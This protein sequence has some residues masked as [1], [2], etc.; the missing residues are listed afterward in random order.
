MQVHRE[1]TSDLDGE[2][3]RRLGSQLGEMES[4]VKE[5]GEVLEVLTGSR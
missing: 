4:V 5:S 1:H 3:K 2:G